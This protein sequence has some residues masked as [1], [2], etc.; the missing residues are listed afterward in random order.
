MR[1][2]QLERY[3]N[4]SLSYPTDIRSVCDTIGAVEID[5]PSPSQNL[6]IQAILLDHENERFDSAEELYQT[7]FANLPEG[8]VGRKYYSDRG[9]HVDTEF[10]GWAD[11]LEQ[12]F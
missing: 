11:E 12:S 1:I 2:Q 6:P 7:I 3:L 10:D 9:G 5:A 4:E 8:Y